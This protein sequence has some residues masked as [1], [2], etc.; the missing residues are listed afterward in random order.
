MCHEAVTAVLD[1]SQAKGAPLFVLMVIA[2]SINRERGEFEWNTRVIA[3]RCRIDITQFRRHRA[4]LVRLGELTVRPITRGR[5]SYATPL[6]KPA[7]ALPDPETCEIT[8]LAETCEITLK[9]PSEKRVKSH[10]ER[11]ISHASAPVPNDQ[12]ITRRI[13]PHA[14]TREGWTEDARLWRVLCADMRRSMS[15]A[16]A[17]WLN[18]YRLYE[19]ATPGAYAIEARSTAAADLLRVNLIDRLSGAIG[20][21]APKKVATFDIVTAAPLRPSPA[22]ALVEG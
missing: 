8:P 22:L 16:Q 14:R 11:V 7:H 13:S 18:S 5:N 9:D 10:P 6:Y 17:D 4:A 1:H 12:E 2:D 15:D 19:T 3:S 21:C 20:R